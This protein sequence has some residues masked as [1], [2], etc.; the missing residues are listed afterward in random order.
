V[1]RAH[2][3]PGIADARTTGQ[4]GPFD[5]DEGMES[6]LREAGFRGVR[7]VLGTVRP[8]FENPEQWYRW[9]RST[10]LRQFWEGIPESERVEVQATVFAAVAECRD[11]TGR[12]GFDQQIRYTIGVL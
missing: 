1:L 3:P 6:L 2:A 4:Q 7:T 8:R 5:S 10:G 9:S 12:I 11:E